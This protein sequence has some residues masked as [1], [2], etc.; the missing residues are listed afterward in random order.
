M[1]IR[2]FPD[3]LRAGVRPPLAALLLALAVR[4]DGV[5]PV[6]VARFIFPQPVEALADAPDDTVVI[7]LAAG[8]TLLALDAAPHTLCP[9][10]RGMLVA[11][12]LRVDDAGPPARAQLEAQ[13]EGPDGPAGFQEVSGAP[14]Q[15]GAWTRVA[16]WLFAGEGRSLRGLRLRVSRAGPYHLLPPGLWHSPET[17]PPDDRPALRV[18]GRHLMAGDAVVR[19]NG[20]NLCAY[21]DDDRDPVQHAMASADE[22]DYAAIA[23]A[24]F[25][26]VRLNC[27]HKCFADA[28]GWAWLDLHRSWAKRQGL[29]LILDLHAPPGGYQGPEYNRKRF[30]QEPELQ[31]AA[32]R[33]WTEAARRYSGDPAIAAFDLINE[34]NPPRDAD[35]WAFV[36]AALPAIRTAGWA[37]PVIVEKSFARDGAFRKLSDANVIYDA[38]FYEPWSFCSGA[39]GRYGD[40]V[41]A[42]VTTRLDRAWLARALREELVSFAEEHDVPCNV[43]EYGIMPA[44]LAAGGDQWLRDVVDLM[45][46]GAVNRQY[47]CWHYFPWGLHDAGWHRRRPAAPHQ[48]ILSVI[49][50]A[51][52]R[53]AGP[54]VP[55]AV[56]VGGTGAP[57]AVR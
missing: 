48:R 40:P 16:G 22:E 15:S 6:P 56:I 18:A 28:G 44:V 13:W 23:A 30:Y 47:W 45:E 2:T 20:V 31:A 26:V 32:I 36:E 41:A 55:R 29:L 14:L 27:W 38:H 50:P 43:G 10:G 49:A 3:A 53:A 5:E 4:A 57:P 35:W 33:F 17:Q 19:L 7:R 34:P 42:G 9:P 24:G 1:T 51:P 52:M 11:F 37:Q 21:S 46:A 54:A 25:N 8:G 39:S 12:W